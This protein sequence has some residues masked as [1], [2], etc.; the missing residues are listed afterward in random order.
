MNAVVSPPWV[1]EVTA[2][3]LAYSDA[4]YEPYLVGAPLSTALVRV[5]E[6]LGLDVDEVARWAGVEPVAVDA[7]EG[8]GEKRPTRGEFQHVAETLA[9]FAA[10]RETHDPQILSGL[11]DVARLG[12]LCLDIEF[13][14]PL[15]MGW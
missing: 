1:A 5:R 15:P 11:D 6:R 3:V 4:L 10:G 7:C 13:V 2:A 8:R 9:G 12:E 14:C